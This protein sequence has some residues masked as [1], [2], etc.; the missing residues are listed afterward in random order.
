MVIETL[1]IGL[2]IGFI[3]YEV[4]GIS[5]GG[6]IA[7]GYL[8]LYIHQPHK[9]AVTLLAALAVWGALEFCSRTLIV[10][11]RRKL[12][13]AL[14]FSFTLKLIIEQWIQPLP[15][16][17]LDIQTIGYII[18]GLIANEITRQRVIPTLASIIIVTAIVFFTVTL[19]QPV[20]H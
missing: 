9:I 6:V 11:G 17:P 8:A 1:F 18:P 7:P 15:M 10:Y 5:A 14:L 20:L 12:L 2:V 16:L 3:F 4:T 19:L 13:L